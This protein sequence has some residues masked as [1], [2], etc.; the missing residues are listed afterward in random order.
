MKFNKLLA[1]LLVSTLFILGA[2]VA[3][4]ASAAQAQTLPCTVT[5]TS[6][7]TNSTISGT[8]LI[9]VTTSCA[10]GTPDIFYRVYVGRS[11]F[12]FTGASYEWNTT[13][14]PNGP[15]D[16]GVIAWNGTGL[17]KEG[18][19][20][21]IPI[22]IANGVATPTPFCRT[23]AGH[24]NM[25]CCRDVSKPWRRGQRDRNCDGCG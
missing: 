15:S 6:P 19:S 3:S 10:P 22:T 13:A 23:H 17:V 5:I 20:P 16:L 8:A 14:T 18:V 9:S 25:R 11:T 21:V 24:G 12:Q 1:L 7:A 2:V 4:L